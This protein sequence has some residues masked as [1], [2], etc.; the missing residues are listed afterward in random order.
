MCLWKLDFSDKNKICTDFLSALGILRCRTGA[1]FYS[2]TSWIKSIHDFSFFCMTNRHVILL[3]FCGL[4][5]HPAS[6]IS[7]GFSGNTLNADG[8]SLG[9]LPFHL[10]PPWL[11]LFIN[12]GSA[13]PHT[14]RSAGS[15][16]GPSPGIS[17]STFL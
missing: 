16:P 13:F 9:R 10:E 14:G 4:C 12:T 1:S 17:A 3:P 11:F 5:P 15:V 7:L 2:I 6:G 8:I